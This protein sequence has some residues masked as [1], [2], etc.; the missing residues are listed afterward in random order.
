MGGFRQLDWRPTRL[1][2]KRG[3]PNSPTQRRVVMTE[4]AIPLVRR[5][6]RNARYTAISNE[7]IDHPRLSPEARIALIYLLSKP[8]D[9][10]L[11]INDLRRLLGTADKICGR[12]KAYEV[13]REL[14]ASAYVVAV[15]E[16]LKGRFH[17]LTYYVFDEP[18][19]D[20]DG[21]RADLCGGAKAEAV[22]SVADGV[23]S[24]RKSPCPETRETVAPPGPETPHPEN[25]HATKEG[26]KQTTE[27]PPPPPKPSS[28]STGAGEGDDWEFSRFWNEWPQAARPRERPYAEKLFEGLALGDQN[29][30]V[31]HAGA[32]RAA[33]RLR[34][35]FA[36][37][38]FYLRDRRFLEFEG[39]PDIDR[40]GYFVITAAREEWAAWLDHYRGRFSAAVMASSIERGFLLTRT[41]WPDVAVATRA[42][43]TNQPPA[44][45]VEERSTATQGARRSERHTERR[46][47]GA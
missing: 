2:I 33:Q 24:A 34:G 28:R 6:R 37:M 9:W 10:Q 19:E 15:E 7:I 47:N 12:N 41:R 40:E 35:E 27:L 20:P 16:L 3:A 44:R 8:D 46:S 45:T 31:A 21:F 23:E 13:L 38:I 1:S 29:L 36:A 25:R 43:A 14:K 17:R 30:A 42:V 5:G 11:Q 32:Y 39:A 26:K 22:S 4:A 18:H